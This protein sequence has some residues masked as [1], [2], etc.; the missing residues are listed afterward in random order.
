MIKC[1]N[2]TPCLNR[3][4]ITLVLGVII[5]AGCKKT[6]SSPA[7]ELTK[8]GAPTKSLYALVSENRSLSIFTA[9]LQ[10]TKLDTVLKSAGPYTVIAPSD[11]AFRSAGLDLSVIQSM[12]KDSLKFII[13]YHIVPG[14]YISNSTR[15][16]ASYRLRNID[17]ALVF[18]EYGVQYVTTD[19]QNPV[20]PN[21]YYVNGQLASSVDSQAVNGTLST[22]DGILLTPAYASSRVVDALAADTTF[23]L[24]YYALHQ[25]QETE[26]VGYGWQSYTV[27]MPMDS[28]FLGDGMLGS[29]YATVFAPT[30]QAMR[31]AGYTRDSIDKLVSANDNHFRYT[32]EYHISCVTPANT[33]YPG[34]SY[35]VGPTFY[36]APLFFNDLLLITGGLDP[37]GGSTGNLSSG[38]TTVNMQG[39]GLLATVCQLYSEVGN[40]QYTVYMSVQTDARRNI[41]LVPYQL[42]KF[43][44]ITYFNTYDAAKLGNPVVTAKGNIYPIDKV[45]NSW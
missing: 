45:L 22:V 1:I 10:L 20:F 23:S 42:Y 35:T 15:P 2:I 29:N 41:S 18:V 31:N 32:L 34:N 24:F 11:S 13:G 43:G 16:Y 4:M 28:A 12:N 27:T 14:Y 17:S 40:D 30:N 9:A 19:V 26:R 6:S 37:T 5:A 38:G 25:V 7:Q 8:A 44:M 33:G 21:D 3:W 36:K 39:Y